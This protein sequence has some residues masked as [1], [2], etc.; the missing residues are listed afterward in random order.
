MKSLRACGLLLAMVSAVVFLSPFGCGSSQKTNPFAGD[1]GGSSSGS[2]GSGGSGGSSVVLGA[3]GGPLLAPDGNVIYADSGSSGGVSTSSSGGGSSGG[4]V[5]DGGGYVN[6]A[7]LP[8]PNNR[9]TLNF[10]YGW[11]FN[12]A[13]VPGANA[14]AFNDS[15]WTDVSLPHTFNDIDSWSDWNSHAT[16]PTIVRRYTGFTWYRKHFTLDASYKGRKVFIE[17]QGIRNGAVFSVNGTNV[18]H[19]EDQVSPCGIDITSAAVFGGDNVIAIQ[20][21]NRSVP[22]ATIVPGTTYD[23]SSTSF[24]PMYGGLYSDANLIVTDPIHQTLP[25][26]LNLGTTGVYVYPTNI[27]SLAR[28]ATI[29]V[30][31]EV[32]NESAGSQM[33]TLSVEIFDE[34]GASVLKMSAMPQA[35][36]AGMKSTL[37][38]SA[39]MTGIHFWA[40][41]YPYLYTARSSLTV[42]G[43]VLDVTDNPLGVRKVTFSA[44]NGLKF[45][46]HSTYLKGYAPREVMDWA[47]SGI[48]QDWMTEYD[49]LL[50][51][52][53]NGNFIRPMHIAPR[54]HMVESADRLGIVMVIPAGDGEGCYDAVRWPQH[55]ALMKNVTI[56]F[57]NNPSA[58]FYEGCNS[59]LTQQQMLDM[60]AVR[61]QWDPHG[62]R[63]A[64]ARGTDQVATPAYEYGSPMDGTGH[65]TT[66]P[67]WAA[68][69]SR[70][71]APRRVWDKYTPVWDPHTMKFV[72]GGYINIVS[73]F[74]VAASN[75]P[76]LNMVGNG[77]N[78]YPSM[79][80][81]QN[82][83][84][85]HALANIFKY[86]AGYQLS[87]FI[88]PAAQRTS[89]GIQAGGAK[90]FFADSD[91]DGRMKDTEVARVS[92]VVDGVRLPK[93]SYYG[94]Q[95]AASLVPAVQ[96]FG[97]WNYPAGTTKTVYVAANTDTVTLATYDPSGTLIKNYT[98]AI[99]TQPGSPNHY[100]WSF[101]GVAFQPGSIKAVGSNAGAMV[102]S[103]EKKTAGAP[104]QLKLTQVAS[105]KGW[106]ADGADIALVDFEVLDAN[107]LRVPTDEAD[108]TFTHSGAGQWLGGYNSGVRQ[109]FPKDDLWTEG[110]INRLLIRSTRTAGTFTITASRS[111]L[112][113]ATIVLTALPFDMGGTTWLT[114]ATSQRYAPVLGPEPPA[115]ADPN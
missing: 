66:I 87:S 4:F 108:V 45:N 3:D 49:Y 90:I 71:E 6:P 14:T 107:G 25:L 88:L 37:T 17:F 29:T 31:S 67:L 38:V 111:G 97:H 56:Y 48:P 86:W 91:A 1:D 74:H 55:V 65:S 81:R 11:K 44:T 99:D 34:S 23:W 101:P 22:D 64:G 105:P 83:M 7:P 43:N 21:D 53:A 54:K 15:A 69:Y 114:T 96:I 89:S 51:K 109:S 70:E 58:L 100:I 32:Q 13:D 2:G 82:S 18:G 41:D 76:L 33:A 10:N 113:S 59:P 30:E 27:D 57:R 47:V 78:Q 98:G 9:V 40:P 102:A 52:Q 77:I 95:V 93:T 42:G 104:T 8:P 16:D 63:F 72:T 28:T 5:N 84:E 26:F 110:G 61:D 75:P 79:D 92:G 73:P 39:P 20:V 94:M 19:Y 85:D 35:V 103:S 24:N 60:K 106:F 115:V 50:I 68:E 46:G 12:K 36:A 80:F 112:T 62:G